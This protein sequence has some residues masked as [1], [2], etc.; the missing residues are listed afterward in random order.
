MSKTHDPRDPARCTGGGA[1]KP[2]G[3]PA[4]KGEGTEA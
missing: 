3:G 2:D 1:A 4:I